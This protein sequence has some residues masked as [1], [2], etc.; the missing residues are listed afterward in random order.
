MTLKKTIRL[1]HLWFGLVS[2]A[3][4]FIISITGCLYAFQ[5]EIQ[6]ATQPFRYV[7][8]RKDAFLPPSK[9]QA[10]ATAQLPGKHLHAVMYSGPE[11]AA[12]AIFFQF[13]PS[14]YFL[15]YLNPYTGE[16]LK[17]KDMDQDFFRIVLN[18]HYYLWLPPAIGQPVVAYTTLIFLFMLI[19]GIVLWWPKNK[20][21]ANQRFWFKW[22]EGLQW[23]RKNYDLHNIIGFY[24]SWV[25]II[26][27][28]TGLVWGFQWF[29]TSVYTLGGGTKSTLF[30]EAVSARPKQP[31]ATE[32][33]PA[34]DRIWARMQAEN[35]TA[36]TMEVHIPDTDTASIAVNIN[37]EEGT[38]WKIDYRYFD[39]YTLKELPVNHIYG[40]FK[41]AK[42]ADKLLRMNYDIHVGAIWG[43]PGKVIAF[44][45][46]LMAASLPVTGFLIWLGRRRKARKS[47]P[48]SA[49][50]STMRRKTPIKYPLRV[51]I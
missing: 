7:A 50:R 4:V 46:S 12:Q 2:G 27:V 34:I 5:E 37:T 10:I 51:R 14:Y 41:E 21:A 40:R 31:V 35:P 36:K 6:N 23:K 49:P 28:L 47:L 22:K 38:F 19:S 25:V 42:R 26:L 20:A 15:V 32:Q 3:V 45:F 30:Q 1:L 16:V 11:K 18:G 33:T 29:S 48:V 43:L 24:S 13:D 17:V 39:Q 8:A 44:C 9:L